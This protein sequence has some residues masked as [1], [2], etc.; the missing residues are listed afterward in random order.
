MDYPE[1]HQTFYIRPDVNYTIDVTKYATLSKKCSSSSITISAPKLSS[2]PIN[3]ESPILILPT[4]SL[5]STYEVTSNSQLLILNITVGK[6][7]YLQLS[8]YTQLNG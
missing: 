2:I 1:L 8:Y 6:S 3:A 4:D 5:F 7:L